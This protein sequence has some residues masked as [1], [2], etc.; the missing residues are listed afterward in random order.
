MIKLRYSKQINAPKKEVHRI[1]LDKPTY[2]IWTSAFNPSSTFEGNWEKG[3]K[4]YFLGICDDGKREG[5]VSE[6]AENIPGEIVSI[7]HKGILDGDKEITEGPQ[8]EKWGN[9]YE[10]Y[11]FEEHDGITTLSIEQDLEESYKEYFDEAWGKALH[12]LKEICEKEA[13]N[14]A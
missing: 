10:I 9:I 3:T 13:G 2:E 5:M 6:I 8:V 14:K 12:R 4:M 7:W 11:R 1:M